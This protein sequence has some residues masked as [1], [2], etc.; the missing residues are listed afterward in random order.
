MMTGFLVGRLSYGVSA[1]LGDYKTVITRFENESKLLSS[2]YVGETLGEI[3]GYTTDGLFKTDEEAAAYMAEIN[4]KNV[5]KG[6]YGG[7]APNNV[8]MAG[9]LKYKDLNGDKAINSGDNTLDNPG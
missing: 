7:A 1:S 4:D 3:W 9:D 6:I 8:L 2:H 5:S